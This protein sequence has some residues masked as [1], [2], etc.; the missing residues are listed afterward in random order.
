MKIKTIIEGWKN[1][2][3]PNNVSESLS[4]ERMA[5]CNP[6]SERKMILGVEVCGLCNCPLVAKTRASENSCGLKK[7]VN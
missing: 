7:W 5:T 6:C 2:L 4:N 1:T 3:I